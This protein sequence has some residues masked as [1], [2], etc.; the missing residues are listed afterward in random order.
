MRQE[1]TDESTR[2]IVKGL[3]GRRLR[4]AAGGEPRARRKKARVK[5]TPASMLRGCYR[6]SHGANGR[7]RTSKS[8]VQGTFGAAACGTLHFAAIR[9]ISR[10]LPSLVQ[11]LKAPSRDI[12]LPSFT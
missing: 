2:R 7:E 12:D 8:I 11:R 4:E 6:V 3:L 9:E 1:G 10:S 5:A